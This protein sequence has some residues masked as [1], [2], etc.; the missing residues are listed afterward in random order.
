MHPIKRRDC[1]YVHARRRLYSRDDCLVCHA[2]SR[3]CTFTVFEAGIASM[4]GLTSRVTN[5]H[6]T[7]DGYTRAVGWSCECTDLA[8]LHV[9]ELLLFLLLNSAGLATAH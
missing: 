3:H 2:E 1:L 9:A 6:A 7:K 8:L 4:N 5:I